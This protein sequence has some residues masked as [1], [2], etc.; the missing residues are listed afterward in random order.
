MAPTKSTTKNSSKT[1]SP[2]LLV[3]DTAPSLAA[4]V[5]ALAT[6]LECRVLQASSISEAR[7][8][9]AREP[10]EILLTETSLPD[11]DGLSLV[12]Q[13][14]KQCA[15]ATALIT[16][17]APTVQELI[18]AMREGAVDFLPKTAGKQQ[19]TQRLK[20]AVEQ[21]HQ[22]ARNE[23]RLDRLSGTVK[24][25]N[26]SRKVVGKKIDLLC[27][28]L[29]Q[30]YSELSRQMDCVRIQEDFRKSLGDA[31]D[32]EQ[33]LC[34]TMDWIMRRLGYSNIAIW[35]VAGE[36]EFEL[37]AY[38]KYTIESNP[39]FIEAM[40]KGLVA[41]TLR[42][43]HVH[44]SGAE[45]RNHLSLEEMTWLAGQA[46]LTETCMYLGETLAVITLFRD[47]ASPFTAEDAAGLRL[48]APLFAT[49]LSSATHKS[50][51]QAENE[52]FHDQSR[53]NDDW[54]KTGSAPPF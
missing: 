31:R 5:N 1:K 22:A 44:L 2:A 47:E 42:H 16:S 38:V 13:L 45:A 24:R 48:I 27:N 52:E 4:T 23:K 8:I 41:Q 11:G 17:D 35:M 49:A 14:R 54:W 30:A 7:A 12:S 39:Q 25:L 33:L 9:M 26:E 19:L 3:V 18:S 20:I 6:D 15:S 21:H 34:H 32:L 51:S 50:Q 10:V 46:V 36:S 40:K 37:G 53:D 29:V 28:D 43:S